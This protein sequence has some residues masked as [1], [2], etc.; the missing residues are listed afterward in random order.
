MYVNLAYLLWYK[1]P[2]NSSVQRG[3]I[4]ESPSGNIEDRITN[5]FFGKG[6]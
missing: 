1:R 4:K 3:E 5:Y 2:A 6:R